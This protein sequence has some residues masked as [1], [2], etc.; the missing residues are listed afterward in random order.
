MENGFDSYRRI[1]LSTTGQTNWTTCSLQI[2]A[3]CLV[4]GFL[5]TKDATVV[6]HSQSFPTLFDARKIPSSLPNGDSSTFPLSK[7]AALTAAD[8]TSFHISLFVVPL[9]SLLWN[10]IKCSSTCSGKMVVSDTEVSFS[11][12]ACFHFSVYKTIN[13]YYGMIWCFNRGLTN[14]RTNLALNNAPFSTPR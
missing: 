6:H 10:K 9:V 11:H 12:F 1:L 14:P 8:F 7:P 4:K 5:R 13:Y 2:W 3:T